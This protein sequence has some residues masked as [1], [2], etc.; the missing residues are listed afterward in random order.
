MNDTTD[1]TAQDPR[2]AR[3]IIMLAPVG[4]D[5]LCTGCGAKPTRETGRCKCVTGPLT[6][7]ALAQAAPPPERVRPGGY[8]TPPFSAA[9]AAQPSGLDFLS[10]EDAAKLDGGAHWEQYPE[11]APPSGLDVG[12]L[13]DAVR[14]G[15]YDPLGM[16]TLDEWEDI[17]ARYAALSPTPD[18][19]EGER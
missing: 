17:A 4:A 5:G 12:A 16:L 10:D 3:R 15:G 7:V 1:P 8:L 11:A 13:M 18:P 6:V 14:Y 2:E 9:Q 19:V